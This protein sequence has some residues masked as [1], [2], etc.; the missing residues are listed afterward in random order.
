MMG[1]FDSRQ[2][3]RMLERMGVNLE[4]VKG[5]EEVIIKTS[6]KDIIVKNASVSEIKSKGIRVFQ[7]MGDQVEEKVKEAPKFTE[8]D[9]QLVAQQAGVSKEKALAAL[10]DSDGDLAKAILKLTT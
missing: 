1:G 8:E 10:A 6:S 5:V 7:V 9:V 2:T 4:E 3:R